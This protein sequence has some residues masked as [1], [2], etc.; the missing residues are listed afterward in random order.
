MPKLSR[1][2]LNE[3]KKA[4]AAAR[5][6]EKAKLAE[7]DPEYVPEEEQ[8]K[9]KRGFTAEQRADLRR[10]TYESD[11]NVNVRYNI[12][13]S[14]LVELPD[15]SIGMVVRDAEEVHLKKNQLRKADTKNAVTAS[16]YYNK[17]YVLTSNGNDWHLASHLRK[18]HQ[19]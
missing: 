17:V 12:N 4:R 10:Q 7:K 3:I 13:M 6:A 8:K 11:H 18:I 19:N 1:S 9:D 5:E 15:G 2:Q 16:K 14:D